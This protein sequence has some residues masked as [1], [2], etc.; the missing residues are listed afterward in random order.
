[1]EDAAKRMQGRQKTD[2]GD[3]SGDVQAQ[4]TVSAKASGQTKTVQG[5]SARQMVITMAMEGQNT[6]TGDSGAMEI[7]TDAW[8]APV[9]GYGEAKEFNQRMAVKLGNA[10]GSGMQQIAQMAAMQGGR[11]NMGEGMDQVAKELSKIE[12]VPVE[13]LTK[14]GGSGVS[15]GSDASA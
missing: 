1:M 11:A 9:P 15:A 2:K 4:I 7:T 13:S 3:K 6:K 5:L 8:Y 10:F 12:G 14:M